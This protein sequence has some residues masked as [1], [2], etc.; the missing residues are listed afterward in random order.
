MNYRT[1]LYSVFCF[2][3]LSQYT[4]LQAQCPDTEVPVLIEVV[5][6]T[7]TAL[8]TSW[9]LS[10]MGV[11]LDSSVASN[12]TICVPATAC[13]S[14]DLYDQYGDGLVNGAY[15]RV[16]YNG[17]TVFEGSN[18][19]GTHSTTDFG[20]C[21]PGYSCHFAIPVN[22]GTYL[23]P[24]ANTWYV[25][26]PDSTGQY[27]FSTCNNTCNTQIWLYTYCQDITVA[28]GPE[29]AI[30]FA[31]AGCGEQARLSLMLQKNQ[32]YYLRIGDENQSC[33]DN[34][35]INWELSFGGQISGCMDIAACNYDPLATI[36][37]ADACLYAPA[38]GDGPDLVV[39]QDEII[40]SLYLSTIPNNDNCYLLEG[41]FSGYGDREVIN[42]TTHIKN[43]GTQDY[44][45]GEPPASI[46]DPTAQFEY[47]PCHNH[48]HYEGYAEYLMLNAQGQQMSV[49]FKN[50]F[51]VMDLECGGGGNY[52]YGCSYMGISAGCGDIYSSGLPCQWIDVT[53]LPAGAYTLVVRVNWDN[54]PDFLGH[55]EV[56]LSNNWAQ[57]C[58]QIDRDPITNAASVTIIEDCAPYTDC[59]G[60]VYGS[61]QLD[62]KG[63]CGGTALFG[64]F[65]ENGILHT[66][67]V[68]QLGNAIL[69]DAVA[70]PCTDLNADNQLDVAD[71]SELVACIM[72]GTGAHTHPSGGTSHNHCQFPVIAI[73]NPNDTVRFSLG[74]LN[75]E[76][77][78]LD[79][80]IE[81]PTHYV[82]NYQLKIRGLDIVG[83]TSI[84]A[85]PDYY[86]NYFV[87][88]NG[89]II[90]VAPTEKRINRYISPTPFLRLYYNTINEPEICINII[91]VLN[92]NYE[93]VNTHISPNCM[94][95]DIFSATPNLPNTQNINSYLSPNPFS[96]SA[97]LWFNN[98]N[99]A[100]HRIV[101]T[102]L[103]GKIWQQYPQVSGN[104]LQID[105]QN[106][107]TGIYTYQII[108]ENGSSTGKMLV[109]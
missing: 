41:C 15:C 65:D 30:A 95:A 81:N 12:A 32:T 6:D 53:N 72:Q 7:W 44:V 84:V 77:K 8:E 107:P 51:C 4:N 102:D 69:Q 2:M 103:N 22:E 23:A 37:N 90:C 93:T 34:G 80:Q 98:P 92:D 89:K 10:S 47:D 96:Q 11:T 106:L 25:V 26:N 85:Q 78:Y 42:F 31:T 9:R 35:G 54:T 39:L 100:P 91:S 45:I 70:T 66:D 43:I 108:G 46:T 29:G 13:L 76:Q 1:L 59:A 56:N 75:T 79:L 73:H 58:L 48:W 86:A 21:T 60:S 97:V 83:A 87:N 57:V 109:W 19:I 17:E 61:S 14:F 82:L 68:Y 18:Q 62:C 5:P 94:P 99:S 40:N 88:S 74:E 50:G 49:G 16:I 64:D 38:C 36:S 28:N 3:L 63:E 20:S 101:I 24:E 52:Q 71:L 33:S 67:D 105:R 27:I 55:Q 104:Q